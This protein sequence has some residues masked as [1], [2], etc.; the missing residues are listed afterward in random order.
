[1]E[2]ASRLPHEYARLMDGPS[3]VPIAGPVAGE[4]HQLAQ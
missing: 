3:L 2:M 4:A 1:M